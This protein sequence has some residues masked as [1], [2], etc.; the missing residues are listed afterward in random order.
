[1]R[2][3]FENAPVG[4][5]NACITDSLIVEAN[6]RFLQM[7]GYDRAEEVIVKKT[8]LDIC[9]DRT[10]QNFIRSELQ[11]KGRVDGLTIP[12]LK[13]DGS[14]IGVLLWVRMNVEQNC[15]LCAIAE[16]D[17]SLAT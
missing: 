1:M 6:Q 2:N 13:R 17:N 3:L 5:F 7:L 12:L 8:I 10:S 9:S 4:I 15:W 16:L 11:T 14:T